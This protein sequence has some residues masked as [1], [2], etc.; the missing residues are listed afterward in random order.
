M[1]LN[2]DVPNTPFFDDKFQNHIPNPAYW[3]RKKAEE[4][5]LR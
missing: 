2:I 1:E 5:I 4:I 3:S